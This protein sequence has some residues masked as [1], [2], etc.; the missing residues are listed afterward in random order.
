MRIRKKRKK[1]TKKNSGGGGGGGFLGWGV[2]DGLG[3][4]HCGM[5]GKCCF[6]K[7]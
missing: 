7:V 3:E 4:V 5:S 6:V 2:W 1:V